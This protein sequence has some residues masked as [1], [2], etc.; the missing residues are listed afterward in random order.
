MTINLNEVAL[1]TIHKNLESVILSNET[2]TARKENFLAKMKQ[3]SID[4]AIIYADREHGAN[5]EYLTGFIPRFEEACLVIHSNGD[6][7]LMLGNEN[8]KLAAHSRIP[9][10]A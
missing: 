10:K 6:S 2:M 4:T 9:A 7:Y 3:Q 8:L 1:P 5:F